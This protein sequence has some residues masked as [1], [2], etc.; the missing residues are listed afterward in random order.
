MFKQ[1][2]SFK[3]IFDLSQKKASLTK[4][5]SAILHSRLNETLV[6]DN[7]EHTN[8]ISINIQFSQ[9]L[10]LQPLL[11]GKVTVNLSL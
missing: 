10:S 11:E 6:E 1:I 8:E 4:V 5:Y 7:D 3:E 2:F 9:D